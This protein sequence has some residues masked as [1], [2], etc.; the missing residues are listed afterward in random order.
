MTNRKTQ[1]PYSSI[2]FEDAR[3]A[4]IN[5]IKLEHGNDFS[6]FYDDASVGNLLLELNAAISDV[7]SFSIDRSFNETLIDHAQMRSSLLGMA[8][9]QGIKIRGKKPSVTILNLSVTLP[10]KGDTPDFSY[11]PKI[12]KGGSFIGGNNSA[13]F[14]LKYN[15]DFNNSTSFNGSPNRIITPNIDSN[16][17]IKS[18]TI[19]KQEIAVNGYSKIYKFIMTEDNA[20][21]FFQITLPD[22]DVISI[23]RVVQL[24]G[25]NYTREPLLEEWMDA[26]LQYYEVDALPQ[27]CVFIDKPSIKNEIFGEWLKTENRFIT[28]YTDRGF[29]KIIFGS[30]NFDSGILTNNNLLKRLNHNLHPLGRIPTPNTTLF[31]KYRVGGG[32]N[33]NIGANTISN[34]NKVDIYVNGSSNSINELVKNSL[35][36]TNPIP[37]LGGIDAPTTEEIRHIIKYNTP[38]ANRAVTLDDYKTII[39]NMDGRY[40]VPYKVS[41]NNIDGKV[42]ISILGQ[43]IDGTVT[44]S[45]TNILKDNLK[46]YLEKFKMV[47]DCVV[48]QDAKIINIGLEI[49]MITAPSLNTQDIISKIIT[50]VKEFFSNDSREIGED[51]FLSQINN[52]IRDVAGIYNIVGIKVFNKV[53]G[54]YSV[55]ETS[56]PYID[57]QTKQINTT[58][59]FVLCGSWDEFFEIK[60]PNKDIVINISDSQF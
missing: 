19:T 3:Q 25:V 29:M 39:Y 45:S 36:V 54:Q 37:A 34:T 15:V 58:D 9:T 40:G 10:T 50:R 60:F 6:A 18:Y 8:R 46:N 28:E 1:L 20:V 42:N 2:N 41:T 16:G 35:T 55:N 13:I 59:S 11:A 17:V 22:L 38:S 30:G 48:I 53:G 56:L 14:E 4:L 26:E 51:I 57:E 33:T 31:I 21:P 52:V 7:L 47:N 23:E 44:N 32:R 49:D 43:N 27:D 12:L 24:N 5:H